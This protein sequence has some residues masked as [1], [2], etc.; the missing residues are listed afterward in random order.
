[1]EKLGL[2]I[3]SWLVHKPDRKG[4]KRKRKNT[5][6]AK[7]RKRGKERKGKRERGK[8]GYYKC[9]LVSCWT[10]ACLCLC[11]WGQLG[12]QTSEFLGRLSDGG[13]E[14]DSSSEY[15]LSSGVRLRLTV[16]VGGGG[17]GGV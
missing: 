14:E 7:K 3:Q 4:E 17:P 11:L 8:E 10:S 12:R 9:N 16:L 2:F 13:G 15:S 1:M 5:K 6:K